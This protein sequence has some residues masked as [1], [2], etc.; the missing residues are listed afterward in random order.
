MEPKFQSSFIPKDSSG[1]QSNQL[2]SFRNKKSGGGGLLAFISKII[3]ALSVLA[4]VGVFGYKFYLRYSIDRM[5]E[6]LEV[7]RVDVEPDTV[8]ELVRINNRI[9]S[10]KEIIASHTVISPFFELLQASTARAVRFT[11]I[12]YINSPEEGIK[13]TLSGQ[14]NSYGALALQADIFSDNQ[15]LTNQLFSDL[16]LD[17]QGNVI[18]T[19][20]ANVSRDLLSYRRRVEQLTPTAPTEEVVSQEQVSEDTITEDNTQDTTI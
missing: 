17:P 12:D 20:T 5:K 16:K 2:E 1:A 6:D 8:Q 3:F 13:V 9:L 19:F 14:A 10:T 7:A 15:Y 18:F 4:A 11:D